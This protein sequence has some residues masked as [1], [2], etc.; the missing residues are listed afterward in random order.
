MLAQVYGTALEKK[1]ASIR[2]RRLKP[3]ALEYES[4]FAPLGT[5]QIMDDRASSCKIARESPI[6]VVCPDGRMLTRTPKLQI[7]VDVISCSQA[8]F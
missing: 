6:S 4:A 1:A 3:A 5:Q 8:P 7:S 2:L